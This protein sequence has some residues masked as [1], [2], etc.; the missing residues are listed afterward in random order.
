MALCAQ[1]DNEKNRQL[2]AISW[3][4]YLQ[5]GLAEQIDQA[6]NRSG[7]ALLQATVR[8]L[9]GGMLS[10][11]CTQCEPT[12]QGTL[13]IVGSDGQ[14]TFVPMQHVREFTVKPYGQT[15]GTNDAPA[16]SSTLSH[17]KKP[18]SALQES[19]AN[20]KA[21]LM[22]LGENEGEND[23][24]ESRYESR[25]KGEKTQTKASPR[26][27]ANDDKSE[28]TPAPALRTKSSQPEYFTDLPVPYGTP[29]PEE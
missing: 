14:T 1:H 23:T 8:F 22:A 19:E 18:L 10:F 5:K 11:L 21:L 16:P 2:V 29:F 28:T 13:R 4:S 20:K 6:K 12:P 3:K 24:N 25:N 26:F 27:G 9:A 7:S 15:D 17:A